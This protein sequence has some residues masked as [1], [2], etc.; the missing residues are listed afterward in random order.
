MTREHQDKLYDLFL[1]AC[2]WEGW[3]CNSCERELLYFT[4]KFT[5]PKLCPSTTS[6][7]ASPR[8]D[9]EGMRLSVSVNGVELFQRT[10]GY[11]V[12]RSTGLFKAA[13]L[14]QVENEKVEKELAQAKS[15]VFP[16]KFDDTDEWDIKEVETILGQ[17]TVSIRHKGFPNDVV[18]R[19]RLCTRGLMTPLALFEK[20]RCGL[21]LERSDASRIVAPLVSKLLDRR[22][23]AA[24]TEINALMRALGG[25]GLV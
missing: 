22:E 7:W 15:S 9:T 10:V 18:L 8:R 13:C 2:T 19:V 25:E 5:H 16:H 14:V 20:G 23:Q 1:T 21:A 6:V 24:R 3:E 12:W 11:E 17:C 4:F